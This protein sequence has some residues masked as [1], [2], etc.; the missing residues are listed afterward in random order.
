MKK[1]HAHHGQVARAPLAAAVAL[2]LLLAPA[3]Q[4]FEF[5]RGELSGSLDTT[6]SYGSSWRVEDQNQFPPMILAWAKA[7][8][9]MWL[10]PPADVAEV[11][12]LQQG[13]AVEGWAK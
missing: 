9:P 8:M 10:I 11:R 3:A 4:A 12:K 5:S 7:A 1:L 6:V 13:E 2:G